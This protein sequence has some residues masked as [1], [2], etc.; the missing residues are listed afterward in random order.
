MSLEEALEY[1][2]RLEQ[3]IVREQNGIKQGSLRKELEKMGANPKAMD[4][5]L[6]KLANLE[7]LK[8]DEDHRVVL[9]AEDEARRIKEQLPELFGR[10]TAGVGH[11]AP[12]GAPVDMDVN[13]YKNMS[14]KDKSNPEVLKA[15]FAKHG[16]AVK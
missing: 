3:H 6:G 4:L 9:G 14:L 7:S 10:S 11:E 1:K 13:A 2:Q 8:Y 15:L 12:Q 16:V 5:L